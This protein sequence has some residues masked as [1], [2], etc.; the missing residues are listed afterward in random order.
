MK[1]LK[2]VMLTL[3]VSMLLSVM[4]VEGSSTNKEYQ[5]FDG[6][7]QSVVQNTPSLNGTMVISG[8]SVSYSCALG[9][10]S[11]QNAQKS[12]TAIY[13]QLVCNGTTYSFLGQYVVNTNGPNYFSGNVSWPDGAA[14]SASAGKTGSG[15]IPASKTAGPSPFG[16]DSWTASSGAG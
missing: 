1:S 7:Y 14:K 10:C 15:T 12:K 2:A 3:G 8:S 6:T 13:F 16:E 5:S 11:V 9:N 4:S